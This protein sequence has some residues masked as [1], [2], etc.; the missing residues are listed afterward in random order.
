MI[1][2]AIVTLTNAAPK[3]P[4]RL[5]RA[6]LAAACIPTSSPAATVRAI[7]T[8]R[9][10]AVGSPRPPEFL[11]GAGPEDPHEFVAGSVSSRA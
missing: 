9:L 3:S 11:P 1:A 10:M 5:D 2:N 7:A 6:E 8:D 4:T